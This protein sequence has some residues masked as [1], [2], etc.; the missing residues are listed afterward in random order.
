MRSEGRV[1]VGTKMWKVMS[2]FWKISFFLLQR[3][4]RSLADF[5]KVRNFPAY[6]PA[7]RIYHTVC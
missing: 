1:K 7:A 2:D 4:N 5:V 3:A 6:V